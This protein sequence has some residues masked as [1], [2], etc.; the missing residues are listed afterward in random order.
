MAVGWIKQGGN[1]E[2]ITTAQPPDSIR[3]Y[4]NRFGL[5]VP[6]LEEEDRLWIGDLYTP[7]LGQKPKDLDGA[8]SLRVA[9]L[10]ITIGKN[11]SKPPVS[12]LIL[13]FDNA[14]TLARFNDDRAWVELLLT[15]SIPLA[16]SRK[17]T[18]INGVTCGVHEEWIYKTL[19]GAHNGIIDF[20]LDETGERTK[21][22]FALRVCVMWASIHVGIIS[23]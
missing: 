21:N 12:D 11:L 19:E 14:S 1:V 16:S 5:D 23:G 15:R 18:V 2:Y 7:T 8:G 6:K 13:F 20:K 3:M 22:L 10:S 9:D 17:V 4:V